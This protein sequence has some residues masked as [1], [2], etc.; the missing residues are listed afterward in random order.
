M[1]AAFVTATGTDIGKTFVSAG[2]IRARIRA[3]GQAGAIKPVMSGYDP[4]HPEKSDAGLLL[5]AMGSAISADA[6]AAISPWRFGAA[7]SPDM[8]AAREGSA[9]PFQ[10]VLGFC[11]AAVSEAPG[12]MLVEGVG[13]VMVPLDAEH[14]MRDLIALLGLPVLLVA[15]SYLGTLSHTLTAAEALRDRGARIAAVVLSESEI[16]PVPGEETAA[17]IRKFLPG[18]PVRLLRRDPDDA[19]FSNLARALGQC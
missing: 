18:I 5:A 1:K 13:G 2:L 4:A 14:T 3:G 10:E 15:G 12:M 11:R 17:C 7:I 6:V 8:A 9:I 19:A 16:S